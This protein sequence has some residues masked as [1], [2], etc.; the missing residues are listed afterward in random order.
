MKNCKE[1]TANL[2][3]KE[4][5]FFLLAFSFLPTLHSIIVLQYLYTVQ[6]GYHKVKVVPCADPRCLDFGT[7]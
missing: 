7:S 6:Y 4:I 2:A 5:D 1:H 3:C